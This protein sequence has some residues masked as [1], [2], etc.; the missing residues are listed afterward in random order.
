MAWLD[1]SSKT[2]SVNPLDGFVWV[3]RDTGCAVSRWQ[4]SPWTRSVDIQ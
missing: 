4:G 1:L 2:T 3:T